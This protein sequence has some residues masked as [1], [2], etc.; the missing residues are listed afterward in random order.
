MSLKN[1]IVIRE[2]FGMQIAFRYRYPIGLFLGLRAE[3]RP[4]PAINI[5]D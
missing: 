2:S 5:T 3:V 4:S 1:M